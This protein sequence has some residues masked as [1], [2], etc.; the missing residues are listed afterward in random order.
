MRLRLLSLGILCSTASVATADFPPVRLDPVSQGEI[1]SPVGI[2]HAGDGTNRLFVTDQRGTIH[3]IQDGSVV[4][5]PFLDI[6]SRLVPERQGFDER[7]LLGLAFHPNFGQAG[8]T[9]ADR[10]YVY[11]SA[12]QPNGNPDDPVNPV[13]HQSI[14]AEYAVTALGSN[15]ADPNSER[16]LLAFD[17]PQ[18]NHNGGHLGFGPDNMLYITTGDGG[19][20]GDNEPGHTGGGP[21]DP[22]GGLGNAQD[23]TNLLGKVLR[24]DV[25]GTNGASGEYGIPNDN[26]FAGAGGGVREEIYA[27]GLRNPWRATF[28]NGPGGTD[29]LIVADVGQGAVEEINIIESGENYGWRIKEGTFDFDATVSPDPDVP[30]IDPVAEYAHPGANNG[31]LEVGLSVTGGV[32]YRGSD[33]PALDGKYIFG[34]WSTSFGTPNGT[35]LGME[36]TS[37]GEFDLSVLSVVGGNPIGEYILAFGLDENGEAYVATKLAAAPS[38]LDPATGL[39]SGAIYRIAA[40]PEPAGI[41]LG[42]L[43]TLASLIVCRSQRH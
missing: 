29:R 23:R 35:L 32:V 7:G 33:F 10:F 6:E 14:I 42:L 19:G 21:D 8:T 28:D 17:E 22:A 2:T 38:G 16:I 12:P 15:V 13:D 9:G 24:I 43:G 20:G 30:L 3:V 37:P 41:V 39:P 1:V 40:V 25:N 11:Y 5:T 34:D 18:F 27:Y 36:E 26:P 4:D 31:L